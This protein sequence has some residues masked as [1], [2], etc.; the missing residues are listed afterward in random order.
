MKLYDLLRVKRAEEM[1]EFQKM[2]AGRAAR[3]VA[4]MRGRDTLSVAR[5][6]AARTIPI[7]Y[8]FPEEP[9]GPSW[10]ATPAARRGSMTPVSAT[11]NGWSDRLNG[12]VR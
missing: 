10:R 3:Q 7:R 11:R 5:V 9:Q 1:P 2:V 12:A 4:A 6:L 8:D